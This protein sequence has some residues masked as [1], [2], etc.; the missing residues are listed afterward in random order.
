MKVRY[1]I[2]LFHL[3]VA[4]EAFGQEKKKA[5]V[6]LFVSHLSEENAAVTRRKGAPKHYFLSR[7]IC[8]KL[9]CR[10]F[11][12]WRT[13]QRNKRYDYNANSKL[14]RKNKMAP[15]TI[16]V[17]QDKPIKMMPVT[18][19]ALP[20]PVSIKSDSIIVLNELLFEVNSY[21]LNQELLPTLDSIATYL[22][23]QPQAMVNIS[24]H[25]DN[26]GKED[27]NLTLSSQR[28]EA[29]AEYLLDKGV[30][31]DRVTFEGLGSALPI[32]PNDTAEGRRK[33][34]RVEILIRGKK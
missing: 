7:V 2:I 19:T 8:F 21:K 25:T 32:L 27:F 3:A 10:A 5:K 30:N 16:A 17:M 20:L 11:I 22:S 9:K 29:V 33:N 23:K 14:S 28:A 13:T 4:T 15:D 26:T 31:P 12:G 1:F 34:R 18:K 6:P 24:G